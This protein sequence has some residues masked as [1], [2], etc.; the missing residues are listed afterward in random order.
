MRTIFCSLSMMLGFALVVRGE[1][2]TN[3]ASVIVKCLNTQA[4]QHTMDIAHVERLAALG[5]VTEAARCF[6]RDDGDGHLNTNATSTAFTDAVLNVTPETIEKASALARK[7]RETPTDNGVILIGIVAA[8][9]TFVNHPPGQFDKAAFTAAFQNLD[10]SRITKVQGLMKTDGLEA[11]SFLL[12]A[13]GYCVKERGVF[14]ASLFNKRFD[15]L[16][17][18]T[19]SGDKD[20]RLATFLKLMRRE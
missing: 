19:F 15:S 13:S 5:I 9:D 6:V 10:E 4:L 8:C 20:Q 17:P 3:V 1:F 11:L 14:N 12:S 7:K 18:S 16:D 2:D